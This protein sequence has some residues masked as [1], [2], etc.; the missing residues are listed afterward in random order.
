MSDCYC[1]SGRAFEECCGPFL[2]GTATPPTPEAV[3]RSRYSAFATANVDYLESSL[4]PETRGDFSRPDTE[5]WARSSEW[6]G[7][8]VRSTSKGGEGDDE[9]FVEFVA[10]FTMDGKPHVHHETGRFARQDGRW[11]YVDGIMGPRPRVATKIGRNDPCP[12]GSGK[13]YKKCHGAAA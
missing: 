7:L 1:K 5:Q 12:C 9:G 11:F 8:E 13:K 6:T 4:L 10:H 3:M 2:A